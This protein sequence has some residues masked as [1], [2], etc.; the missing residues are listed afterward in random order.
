MSNQAEIEELRKSEREFKLAQAQ[1]ILEEQRQQR[2]KWLE[3][4]ESLSAQKSR[5][6]PPILNDIEE[7]KRMTDKL[8]LLLRG[9]AG[10]SED[11]GDSYGARGSVDGGRGSR[12]SLGGGDNDISGPFEDED[13]NLYKTLED[14]YLAEAMKRG[15]TPEEAWKFINEMTVRYKANAKDAL[16]LRLQIETERNKR[17]ELEKN[18]EELRQK[19][20]REREA[21]DAVKFEAKRREEL[22]RAEKERQRQEEDAR[23][24]EIMRREIEARKREEER[25]A[26]EEEKAKKE[27][28]KVVNRMEKHDRLNGKPS[29]RVVAEVDESKL[30]DEE[31]RRRREE[32]EAEERRLTEEERRRHEIARK[33][34]GEAIEGE[35]KADPLSDNR[36]WIKNIN[37]YSSNA[38]TIKQ[39]VKTTD[40]PDML[41]FREKMIKFASQQQQ[42]SPLP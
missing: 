29:S 31:R 14:M 34:V 6:I 11:A 41:S 37:E 10:G 35:H 1:A 20:Q 28:V 32:R 30:T 39:R 13:G 36:E 15:M 5:E 33:V 8:E 2:L 4:M 25:L 22:E 9:A 23:Q 21:R 38:T 26:A 12:G 40:T 27:L 3:K 7:M 16:V 24:L 42:S 18:L 19:I 17:H